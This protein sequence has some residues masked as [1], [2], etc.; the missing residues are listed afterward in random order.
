MTSGV[1]VLA[2]RK[3]GTHATKT[4]CFFSLRKHADVHRWPSQKEGSTRSQASGD[5]H[6][7]HQPLK[8]HENYDT[9]NRRYFLLYPQSAAASFKTFQNHGLNSRTCYNS[10]VPGC[11]FLDFALHER[12]APC[13]LISW[14]TGG[15]LDRAPLGTGSLLRCAKSALART[16]RVLGL[17]LLRHEAA[18]T[19]RA[20]PPPAS[21]TT[22]RRQRHPDTVKMGVH[23]GAK[24]HTTECT[25]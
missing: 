13:D 2:T 23:G 12:P 20:F 3:H 9:L 18:S 15:T 11:F 24:V 21:A 17:V 4:F 10:Y 5:K 14:K 6:Q 1:G 19:A 7:S 25:Y 16:R 22:A 8:K